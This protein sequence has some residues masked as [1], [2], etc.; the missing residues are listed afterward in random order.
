M[1]IEGI[2]VSRR[3][4]Q[5][6]PSYRQRIVRNEGC[7]EHCPASRDPLNSRSNSNIQWVSTPR[8][9]LQFPSNV[10]LFFLFLLL[11]TF[12]SSV[13]NFTAVRNFRPSRLEVSKNREGSARISA[14]IRI[15]PLLFT[16][17][18]RGCESSRQRRCRG[19]RF[20]TVH[21]FYACISTTK[22]S[23]EKFF[24]DISLIGSSRVSIYTFPA[25]SLV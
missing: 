22:C 10:P 19:Q 12:I 17:S 25:R 16:I 3:Y 20:S 24:F 7:P 4:Y 2:L 21:G 9:P 23:L 18:S 15:F 14:K 6:P 11:L 1:N 5:P 13:N 8:P